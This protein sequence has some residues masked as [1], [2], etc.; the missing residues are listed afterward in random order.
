M[1]PHETPSRLRLLPAF[2]GVPLA[3]LP[4]LVAGLAVAGVVVALSGPWVALWTSDRWAALGL[5]LALGL[6]AGALPA[7]GAAP[8]VVYG[9]SVPRFV[10][11]LVRDRARP[12][13]AIWRPVPPCAP[14][15]PAVGQPAP[16][17]DAWGAD[18]EEW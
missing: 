5:R 8:G 4:W 7:L 2:Y 17:A 18:R 9:H 10:R 3:A 13:L 1:D 15:A 12:H 14:V 11:L 16:V 6:A